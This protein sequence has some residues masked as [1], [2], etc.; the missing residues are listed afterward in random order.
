MEVNIKEKYTEILRIFQ[1]K[2]K[3]SLEE[4][5]YFHILY[6]K[7]HKI[8]SEVEKYY[9]YKDAIQDETTVCQEILMKM[10][11]IH[12]T[13]LV[14]HYCNM[15]SFEENMINNKITCENLWIKIAEKKYDGRYV[16]KDIEKLN[17]ISLQHVAERIINNIPITDISDLT[18][19]KDLSNL[20]MAYLDLSGIKLS[21]VVFNNTILRGVALKNSSLRS[22][23]FIGVDFSYA[24]LSN[25]DL[26][27]SE[28]RDS[29][30][31]GAKI[32]KANLSSTNLINLD[33]TRASTIDVNKNASKT[34][35]VIGIH[36]DTQSSRLEQEGGELT[37]KSASPS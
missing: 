2:N 27:G 1:E 12:V 35:N 24:D 30:F 13:E 32:D 3:E 25:A 11:K 23:L 21:Q 20:N 37:L 6:R 33:L 7:T 9:L 19:N 22:C 16:I 36:N 4:H 29:I 18:S 5:E 15:L 28:I 34:T 8:F 17:D 31:I 10:E 14:R 26:T